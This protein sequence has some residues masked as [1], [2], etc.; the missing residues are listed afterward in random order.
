MRHQYQRN[1]S[2]AP[3]PAPVMISSFHAP[4]IDSMRNATAAEATV[5]RTVTTRDAMT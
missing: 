3:V 5:S 2:T 1:S 4:P